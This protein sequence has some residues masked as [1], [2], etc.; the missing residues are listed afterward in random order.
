MW[1]HMCIVSHVIIDILF[2]WDWEYCFACGYWALKDR[3]HAWG[4]FIVALMLY[5]VTYLQNMAIR[6][7]CSY[8]EKVFSKQ[9]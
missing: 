2:Y 1:I 7:D 6:F 9:Q 3:M 5:N 8:F 4:S